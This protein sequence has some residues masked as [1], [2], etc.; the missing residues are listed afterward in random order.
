MTKRPLKLP[1]N[2]D[3]VGSLE[4]SGLE[5]H[6]P[7]SRERAGRREP[8]VELDWSRTEYIPLPP[9]PKSW[10][11]R[12]R[13]DFHMVYNH[14]KTGP[15]IKAGIAGQYEEVV[16]LAYGLSPDQRKGRVGDAIVEAYRKLIVQ[17][18]KA[19]HLAA[20]AEHSIEMFDMV[21]GAVEDVDRRR[22]NRILKQMDQS[23]QSH[24]YTPI[25]APRPASQPWFTVQDGA[26]WTITEERRLRDHERPSQAFEVAAIDEWGTWMLDRRGSSAD[27][28]DVK[29]VLRRLGRL[30]QLVGEKYLYHDAYRTS[31]GS[32][33]SNIAIMDTGGKLHIYDSAL[34]LVMEWNL[35]EDP[36][37][38]DHFRTIDTNYWGEFKSQ[39]RVVN[40]APEGDR[41]LFTFADE[42]WCCTLTG[43]ALWGVATPLNEGWKRVTGKAESFGVEQDVE[44]ALG[45]LGLHLPVTPDEIKRQYRALAMTH[46]PDRNP[47]NPGAGDKMKELNWAFQVLTGVDPNTLE[48]EA[49]NITHF[50]RT[51]ADRVV[52]LGAFQIEF[53]LGGGSPQDWVY[54]ASFAASDGCAYVA[55]YSGKIV[56]LSR[57]GKPLAVFDIG[58]FPQEI[59]EIGRNTYF[60]T[61]T[62][63][64]IVEDRTKLAAI[65]DVFEPGRL[66]AYP[67]GFGILKSRKL[68]WYTVSGAKAGE[69]FTRDP[70]KMIHKTDGGAIVQ[71]R[72]HQAEVRGPGL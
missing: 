26:G 32:T 14:P 30:G 37:V 53:T 15:V 72:Q 71:T 62:R 38:V 55:T 34:N 29:S 64:Y 66:L 20:A 40:V 52:D 69:L 43:V 63:L 7:G 49:S 10:E 41:F 57:E 70:I 48:F 27:R 46:H 54:A 21:P 28:S 50:A 68:E 12:D 39:V 35:Q 8:P 51:A 25:D 3:D 31:R 59:T 44:Y 17:Q 24:G 65:I 42:A 47:N 1:G 19:G 23:G 67:S 33:G 36:R 9:S 2:T 58:F 16:E 61:F 60:L 56:L 13:G 6:A 45:L 22:F 11:T 4:S 5:R 18:M